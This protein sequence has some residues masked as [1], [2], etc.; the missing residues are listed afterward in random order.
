MTI[1]FLTG[2]LSV[3]GDIYSAQANRAEA[4][5]NRDFQ[6]RMSSTSAQRAVEDYKAAGL[7]PALAY[8]RG[9]SSP[10]GAQANIGNPLTSGIANAQSARALQQD[11]KIKAAQSDMDLR[12]KAAQV[13]AAHAANAQAN[14]QAQVNVDQSNLL[15][16]THNFNQIVQPTTKRLMDTDLVLRE[17]GIPR[18]QNEAALEKTLGEWK[19]GL[20]SAKTAAELL[21]AIMSAR[22]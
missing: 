21:R 14:T 15:R 17:L 8:D 2:A 16:Q 9:A 6:E 18:L 22:K 1:P 3:A 19:P 5:R 10:S 12:L 13:G 7:N 20:A 4:Q 11:L